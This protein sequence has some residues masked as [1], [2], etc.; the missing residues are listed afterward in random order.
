MLGEVENGNTKTKKKYIE[1]IDG[2][3]NSPV[4]TNVRFMT[5]HNSIWSEA[6][7]MPV[8]IWKCVLSFSRRTI[9]VKIDLFSQEI[10][11]IE[12]I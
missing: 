8:T 10:N 11:F 1:T 12:E 7:I 3:I 4:T 6:L 2:H 9:S 5:E